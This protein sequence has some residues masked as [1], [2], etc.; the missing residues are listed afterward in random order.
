[1]RFERFTQLTI[2][3]KEEKLIRAFHKIST[4]AERDKN[5]CKSV[6]NF[7]RIGEIYS[8]MLQVMCDLRNFVANLL[9]DEDI[10]TKPACH[11][12]DPSI[13]GIE[14]LAWDFEL[15]LDVIV[16]SLENNELQNHEKCDKL[17]KKAHKLYDDIKF[18]EKKYR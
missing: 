16:Q 6:N 4:R 9:N 18:F 1:M 11:N 12:K 8:D 13:F 10:E 7:F 3:Q 5:I 14:F 2:M 17:F 15:I